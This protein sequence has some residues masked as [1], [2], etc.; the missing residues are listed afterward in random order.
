MSIPCAR[1]NTGSAYHSHYT[2]CHRIHCLAHSSDFPSPGGH[3]AHWLGRRYCDDRICSRR[4]DRLLCLVW[5]RTGPGQGYLDDPVQRHIQRLTHFLSDARLLRQLGLSDQGRASSLPLKS[6]SAELVPACLLRHDW[7]CCTVRDRFLLV[8]YLSV[9]ADQ[10]YLEPMVRF[11]TRGAPSNL[12]ELNYHR[13]GEHEGECLN[14]YVGSYVNAAINMLLD[15]AILVMPMPMLIKLHTSYSW[16]R[17]FHILIMF[18]F[19]AIVTVFSALRVRNLVNFKDLVNPTWSF[20]D[21]GIWSISEMFVGIICACLPANK[22]FFMRLVPQW[23][24]K[25]VADSEPAS[26][27]KKNGK[28]GSSSR[29]GNSKWSSKFSGGRDNGRAPRIPTAALTAVSSFHDNRDSKHFEPLSGDPEEGMPLEERK[30]PVARN[31]AFGGT[32]RSQPSY[33]KSMMARD[34]S[35]DTARSAKQWS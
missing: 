29:S 27:G 35:R 17:K 2:L 14:I 18:S 23:L 20:I 21:V 1:P 28:E 32:V 13:D 19:G 12:S 8:L 33:G 10:L 26:S 16:K 6:I 3:R 22:V 4:S 24:G 11:V 15:V 34:P 7:D 5:A 30:L 25:S 31:T 9:P